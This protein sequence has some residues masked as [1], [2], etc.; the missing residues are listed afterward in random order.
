MHQHPA[1]FPAKIM[2]QVLR[3]SRSGWYA[4]LKRRQMPSP[5]QLLCRKNSATA[6]PA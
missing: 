2:A 6:F 5:R 4:W 1:A 3:V